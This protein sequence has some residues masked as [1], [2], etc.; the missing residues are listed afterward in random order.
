MRL[1]RRIFMTADDGG[2]GSSQDR[3]EFAFI[4][5]ANI[6]DSYSDYDS[7]SDFEDDENESENEVSFDENEHVQGNYEQIYERYNDEQTLLQADHIYKWIDGEAPH[8][9]DLDT[10]IF[11]TDELKQ[12]IHKLTQ[13]QLFEL[14]FT[15]NIKNLVIEASREHGLDLSIDKLNMFVGILL[16]SIFNIR[17]SSKDYWSKSPLLHS[18]AVSNAMTEKEFSRIRS[19]LKFAK[20]AEKNLNDPIW[21]IRIFAEEFRKQLQQFGFFS[22]NMSVDESMIEF[23]GRLSIKQFMPLKPIRFGIKMWSLCTVS[24]F[25]LDFDIYCGKKFEDKHQ[26]LKNCTLGTRVVLKA[27]RDFLLKT[28]SDKL[29]DYHVAFDNFFTS[30]DLMIH[31]NELGL[32]ATGTVRRD[33]VY[34]MKEKLNKKGKLVPFREIVPIE[35]DKKCDRGTFTVK[36]D[37]KSKVNFVSV[38][39]SKVVSVL[40]TASGVEPITPVSRYSKTTRAKENINF[41]ASFS[42]YNKTMGGVDLQDQHCNDAKINVKS[43]KWTWSVFCRIISASI[44]NAF[45]LWKQHSGNDSDNKYGIKEFTM[46]VA[47]V[48]LSPRKSVIENHKFCWIPVRRQ[49]HICKK[50]VSTSCI[51][52]KNHFCTACFTISHGIDVHESTSNKKKGYC[53]GQ[54]CEKRTSTY[55]EGCSD[56]ICPECF[57]GYHKTKKIKTI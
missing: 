17:K 30:P 42:V 6:D 55:C 23:Y 28:P 46:A 11:L 50:K 56:H 14:F 21:R 52:C 18:D 7:E 34:E 48:Y 19:Q 27:L 16:F 45:I 29:K 33:R 35:L 12:N 24:G 41:P 39:D 32:K 37:E 47:D 9:H 3:A 4:P 13:T 15:D 57:E 31:L 1:A 54:E 53:S 5:N 43:K 51:D 20:S 44:S 25:L 26:K 8:V 22:S 38:M 10:K 40:S 49:C 36:H 2:H